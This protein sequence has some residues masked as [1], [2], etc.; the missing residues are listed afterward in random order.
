[1]IAPCRKISFNDMFL[2]GFKMLNRVIT[3]EDIKDE[4]QKFDTLL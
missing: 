1:M 3:L 2:D 4:I